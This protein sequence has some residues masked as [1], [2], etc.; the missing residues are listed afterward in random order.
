MREGWARSLRSPG[1]NVTGLTVTYPELGPKRLELLK[2]VLPALTRVALLLA[3]SELDAADMV[4]NMQAPAQQLGLQLQVIETRGPH[5]FERGFDAARQGRAQALCALATTLIVAH[6]ARLADLAMQHRL[7][8]ISDFSLV[9]DAGLMMAYGADL[10]DLAR[11]AAQHVDKILKGARP[12][13]LPIERPAKFE[14]TLNMRTARTLGVA[15][16]ANVLRRADKVI[17]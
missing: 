13:D 16:P 8:S 7:P 12:G 3:P 5:D 4:G 1:G 15:V 2:E 9:A 17:E 14:L 6:R 11:R 10:L